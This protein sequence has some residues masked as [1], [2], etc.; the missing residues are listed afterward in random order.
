MKIAIGAAAGAATLRSFFIDSLKGAV[1]FSTVLD[2]QA[3]WTLGMVP[4]F[5]SFSY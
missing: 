2:L 5:P 3:R 4:R 1:P